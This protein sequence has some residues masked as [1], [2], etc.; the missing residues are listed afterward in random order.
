MADDEQGLS[1]HRS[2]RRQIGVVGAAPLQDRD[3]LAA[4]FE[5]AK[6]QPKGFVAALNN[7]GAAN[8]THQMDLLALPRD[9]DGS[10]YAL[11]VADVATRRAAA[12]P[13]RAKTADA[14]TKALRDIYT[15]DD[16]L[17]PPARAE[18]DAG[19]EF[20]GSTAAFLEKAGAMIRYG[21]PGRHRQQALVERMNGIIGRAIMIR[22]SG[23]ELLTGKPS[24]EWVDDL[25][26]IVAELNRRIQ[27]DPP[28]LPHDVPPPANAEDRDILLEGTLVRRKNDRPTGVL[29]NHL[30][31]SQRAGDPTYETRGRRI[32]SQLIRPG[33][34]V[35]YILAG[36]PNVTY[37]RWELQ[38]VP[39]DERAPSAAAVA[40]PR[41]ALL[42]VA[43]HDFRA[44]GD[45]YLVEGRG[46]PEGPHEWRTRASLLR[47]AAGKE[48]V[49]NWD[50][51]HSPRRSPRLART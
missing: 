45:S 47:S 29:G 19:G 49:R 35:R 42:P 17:K 32:V 43:L 27:R 30:P 26:R 5:P 31:G 38:V 22:Q 40:R 2:S 23:Q 50:S 7:A 13:L 25:P 33:S 8:T 18:C 16:V 4:V 34:S 48:L 46:R 39:A 44:S 10:R 12:R 11:V 1:A 36:L 9:P 21:E 41:A 14:V 6:R 3:E 15:R 24:T 37:G 51:R 28:P 20:H